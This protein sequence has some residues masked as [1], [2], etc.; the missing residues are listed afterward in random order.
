MSS[1]VSR[2]PPLA[3]SV[4]QA[5][6]R[7][8]MSIRLGTST[9]FFRRAKLRRVRR[10]SAA[11]KKRLPSEGEERAEE[12]AEA[13]LAK[14]AQPSDALKGAASAHGPRPRHT[15]MWR[16]VVLHGRLRLL[17]S[18]STVPENGANC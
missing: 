7:R 16:V 1:I 2:R 4:S 8:C 15:R 9:V 10:A 18:E 3:G 6:E 17:A 13:R 5:N 11:A 14:I 12:G